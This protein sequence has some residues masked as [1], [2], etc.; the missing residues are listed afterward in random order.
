MAEN[1]T[2]TWKQDMEQK[3]DAL[4]QEL[5]RMKLNSGPAPAAA[6]A[7]ASPAPYEF[8]PSAGKVYTVDRGLSIGGYGELIYQSFE[9][10]KADSPVGDETEP[11]NAE[12]NLARWVLYTGY[13]FTDKI[14]FDSELEVEAANSSKSGEVEAEF[15]FLDFALSKPIGLRVGELLLPIGLTNEYHEPTVFNSVLRPDVEQF[16]IPTTWHENGAGYY[17]SLGPWAYRGYVVAGLRA[18]ADE[19]MNQDGFQPDIGLLEGRQEGSRSRAHDLAY[20]QRLDYI[21][22][23]G[24]LIGG[25]VYL[26]NAGQGDTLADG[27][28]INA[29]LTMW[30]VHLKGNA[31]GFDWR[32]LYTQTT[33]GGVGEIDQANGLT[34]NQSVGQ[35]L[36]GGY[37]E[38]AYDVFTIMMP[39]AGQSLSPFFRYERY[40]TQ[41]TVP[42]G[43]SS[44]P[45]NDRRVYTMGLS[46]KPIPRVVLKADYQVRAS[47][48]GGGV[49]QFN[50]G[51]GYE[52]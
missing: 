11:R 41:G 3:I 35:Y 30:E 7:A 12:L 5:E 18:A 39:G 45:A 49:N 52:F 26:D 4:T 1:S 10:A 15:A 42:S 17:G 19:N 6:P 43:Y 34:G 22:I 20:A 33:I 28:R 40:N 13:R 23:P 31:R 27:T 29:P 37:I 44:D 46:Y 48:G 36:W 14:V 9:H 51:A 24:S 25:S 16:L 50:A 8:G 47:H 38:V 32:A 21:G 2:D